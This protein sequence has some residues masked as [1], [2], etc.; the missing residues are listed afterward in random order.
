MKTRLFLPFLALL[1][2]A[3]PAAAQTEDI[4]YATA[5]RFENGLMIW[6]SDTGQIWALADN[7]LAFDFP[8]QAYSH[9]PDNPIFGT[10]PS[11][12][13]PI[14]GFG[15]VWGHYPT[16]RDDLGW[17]TL[18]E[19]GF[20]M[21]VR[22]VG[23][24]TYLTQFDQSVIQINPDLTWHRIEGPVVNQ[25][26]ILGFSATPG[27]VVRGEQVTLSWRASGTQLTLIEVYDV[28]NS[29]VPLTVIQS[30]P[31][32]GTLTYRIPAEV[33]DGVRFVLWAVN[34]SNHPVPV[35]LWERV[36]QAELVVDVH[37]NLSH[38]VITQAAFQPYENGFMLWR[39]DNGDVLVFGKQGQLLGYAESVY[40]VWPGVPEDAD[41][42]P[43]RVRPVNAF[44]KVWGHY[45][46][47][48]ALIG[49][50]LGPEQGYQT[51]IVWESAT[52]FIQHITLP[53]GRVVRTA[54]YSW[55]YE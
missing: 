16:V 28:N 52:A 19:M 36:V 22:V 38:S 9:L 20:D 5:Q 27:S 46:E 8:T 37:P 48:R 32:T 50:A 41:I 49:Y 26:S 23:G 14:F 55:Q 44:G 15:K 42:P 29:Q 18:R 51:T 34:R 33:T 45:D 39:G 54:E 17:P 31:L 12:L 24:T 1:L 11:R 47:A 13:R 40:A 6:R 53:D 4:V 30:L 10:P 25:P 21:P 35:T 2:V 43:N 7:G 3:L